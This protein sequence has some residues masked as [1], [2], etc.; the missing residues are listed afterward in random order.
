[1][2]DAW[3]SS[4]LSRRGILVE[5]RSWWQQGSERE[6]G[7]SGSTRNDRLSRPFAEVG[8]HTPLAQRTPR[9]TDVTAVQ[10]QPVM[11]MKPVFRWHHLIELRLDLE[12]C[13][14]R[15][16]AGPVAHA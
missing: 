10:D 13:L 1:M 6:P 8:N 11:G 4:L 7:G 15:C 3:R 14:A 5:R 16:H 12:R 2:T 9:K